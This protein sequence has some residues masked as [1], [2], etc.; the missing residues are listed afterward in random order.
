MMHELSVGEGKWGWGRRFGR[1]NF[2][3]LF[4]AFFVSLEI[5]VPLLED[6]LVSAYMLLVGYR[7]L[8]KLLSIAR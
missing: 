2:P 3:R 5:S 8:G 6:S 1:G 7:A 4:L